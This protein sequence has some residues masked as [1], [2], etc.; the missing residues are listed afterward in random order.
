MGDRFYIR[1]ETMHL[2]DRGTTENVHNLPP[3]LLSKRTVVNIN[4]ADD[5]EYLK[6]EGVLLFII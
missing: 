2:G 4:I 6:P 1:I 5:R 3:E